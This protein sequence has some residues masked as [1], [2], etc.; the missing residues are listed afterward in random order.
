M[1]RETGRELTVVAMDDCEFLV[2]DVLDFP[3]TGLK[4][5]IL[6]DLEERFKLFR[7][8]PFM[9]EIDDETIES[10]V[11]ETKTLHASHDSVIV[12]NSKKCNHIYLICQVS[13]ASV[14]S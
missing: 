14:V 9:Q 11:I 5:I 12:K 13:V 4:P 10:L 8:H 6:D 1:C 3:D 7:R 2:V